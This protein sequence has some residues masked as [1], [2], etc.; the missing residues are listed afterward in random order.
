MNQKTKRILS[1]SLVLAMLAGMVF[2]ATLVAQAA[3][4][5]TVPSGGPSAG[6]PAMRIF[7]ITENDT[8]YGTISADK[9]TA[10]TGSRITLTAVPDAGYML[11]SFV[12]VDSEGNVITVMSENGKYYFI[13]P[14]NPVS[15][16]A[17]FIKQLAQ[18]TQTGVADKLD[19]GNHIIYLRGYPD[20]SIQPYGNITRAE[21]AMAFYRL[22]KNQDVK[23][24]ASFIDVPQ[25]A[26]YAE[27]VN[28]LASLGIIN[29]YKD[30]S[31]LPNKAITRAEFAA[32]AT[33]FADA[34]GGTVEFSDVPD[35]FWAK[36]NI[37]TAAA[38]GWINGYEDGTFRPN[39]LIRRA[40]AA[41]IVNHML[42]RIA[43][44]SFI[45]ANRSELIQFTDLQDPTAWYYLDM[46]ESS[47][48][49]IFDV[50]NG[51]EKWKK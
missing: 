10:A 44:A 1:L 8:T 20:G 39:G 38:Y 2:S 41:T 45:L 26:W 15:I 4:D 17:T 29:G 21:C 18:P 50:I 12:V 46:V 42:Y 49:H 13:M 11:A 7:S 6:G 14:E 32:V 5:P 16:S 47:T 36:D 40:E 33:R 43:D 9:I 25:D 30:G 28:V 37:A 22:L 35:D 19:T 31:F 23:I 3:G 51:V 24:T 34:K 27:A 48:A